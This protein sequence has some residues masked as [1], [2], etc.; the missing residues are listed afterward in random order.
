MTMTNS[1]SKFFIIF[2]LLLL[3]ESAYLYWQ[4][5]TPK[6]LSFNI[7]NE[8]S[9]L[10]SSPDILPSGSSSEKTNFSDLNNGS[11]TVVS[12]Q[13]IS[14]K[15]NVS[16][17]EFNPVSNKT[18]PIGLVIKDL[19]IRLNVFPSE[20]KS[21]NWE[22]T[23]QGVSYL[24]NSN[25]PGETGNSII[26]GHNWPSL[27]GDLVNIK[28]GQEIDIYMS[29][30]TVKRFIVDNILVVTP[31]Q[32]SVLNKTDD[33]RLTVYTCTGF[34]DTKRFVVSGKLIENT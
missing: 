16:Q 32:S 27:L 4:R 28:K 20:V 26:Y 23:T 34:L 12:N 18:L 22:S 7:E 24:L 30:K 17:F 11:S 31:E 21:N 9:M 3:L 25:L 8:S 19:G 13:G 5:I 6:N 29:D 15:D 1:V 33:K 2:G 14:A 10:K